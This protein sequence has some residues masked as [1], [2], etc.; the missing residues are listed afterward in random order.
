MFPDVGQKNAKTSYE[1]PTPGLIGQSGS[2]PAH[3]DTSGGRLSQHTSG[4]RLSQNTSWEKRTTVSKP[5]L[6]QML[7]TTTQLAPE[8]LKEEARVSFVEPQQ[9]QRKSKG[10]TAGVEN[11]GTFKES[12]KL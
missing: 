2:Q 5:K 6:G 9:D 7:A 4:G 3:G 8:D 12:L 1:I 11:R 10:G